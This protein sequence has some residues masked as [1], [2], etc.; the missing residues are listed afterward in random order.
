VKSRYLSIGLVTGLLLCS[1]VALNV[2]AQS[3]KQVTPGDQ[4]VVTDEEKKLIDETMGG[5]IAP[6]NM[7]GIEVP[8]Y[9]GEMSDRIANDRGN[10]ITPEKDQRS[11]KRPRLRSGL[12]FDKQF[13]HLKNENPYAPNSKPMSRPNTVSFGAPRKM[14][15]LPGYQPDALILTSEQL[16]TLAILSHKRVN[17]NRMTDDMEAE[18]GLP[19]GTSKMMNET[20]QLRI[21]GMLPFEAMTKTQVDSVMKLVAARQGEERRKAAEAGWDSLSSLA[22]TMRFIKS[23]PESTYVAMGMSDTYISETKEDY[24]NSVGRLKEALDALEQIKKGEE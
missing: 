11:S 10:V 5:A 3:T 13:G 14:S 6:R 18:Y 9:S 1:V 7:D 16:K 12:S 19:P 8:R 15:Y 17:I 21:D 20:Q 24:G 22:D 23:I 4:N 2:S